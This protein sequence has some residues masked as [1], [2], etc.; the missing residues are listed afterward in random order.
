MVSQDKE[1]KIASVVPVSLRHRLLAKLIDGLVFVILFQTVHAFAETAALIMGVLFWLVVDLFLNRRSLGKR[2]FKML[3]CHEDSEKTVQ[4]WQLLLRN[5]VFA[6]A[7]LLYC[8]PFWG[9]YLNIIVVFPL[10]LLEVLLMYI[11]DSGTRLFDIL[12]ATVVVYE[13]DTGN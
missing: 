2:Y 11:M 13:S 4:V 3:I 8:F 6:T 1:K 5:V 7:V 9:W 12:S 10:L